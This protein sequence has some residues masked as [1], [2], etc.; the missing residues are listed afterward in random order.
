MNPP[1]R[2][3]SLLFFGYLLF[4]LALLGG[5]FIPLFKNPHMALSGHLSGL[6][7][8]MFLILL[9]L[10]WERLRLQGRSASLVFGL[11][12]YATY[13]N[14]VTNLLGA[15]MGTGTLTPLA[16]GGRVG[17]PW[18]EIVVNVGAVTLGIA[19]LTCT[20]LIL[21]S[22]RRPATGQVAADR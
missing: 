2:S 16:A 4:L 17:K 10:V 7:N 3:R 6:L 19:I 15:S 14:W 12:L 8:A 21:R 1:D 22:L 18:Q 11:A 13:T 9:G 20:V 5:L